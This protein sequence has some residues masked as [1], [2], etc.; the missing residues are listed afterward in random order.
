M[1]D[2]CDTYTVNP[3]QP[4]Q[5]CAPT[6]RGK[7]L[8]PKL[9]PLTLRSIYFP[10][11]HS[12]V[13]GTKRLHWPFC[14]HTAHIIIVLLKSP[15]TTITLKGTLG[16]PLCHGSVSAEA[17]KHVYESAHSAAT[18]IFLCLCVNMWLRTE[19]QWFSWCECKGAVH[20]RDQSFK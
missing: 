5:K 16:C 19:I 15:L 1:S 10:V 12:L 4:R 18:A 8:I 14:L 7:P 2:L 17:Q 6:L 9:C 20:S 3:F 13:T 11:V